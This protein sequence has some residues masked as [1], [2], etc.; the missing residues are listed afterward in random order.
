MICTNVGYSGHKGEG[1]TISRLCALFVVM[2]ILSA[3]Q[4]PRPA[5]VEVVESEDGYRL[6]VNGTPFMVNG[7]N[8][9]YFPIGTNYAFILWEQPDAFIEKALHDEMT[10]LQAM[11]VNAIRVYTGIQPRWV[12]YIYENYGIYTMLNHSFGRYGV[13]LESGWEPNT[14]YASPEVA[15]ILLEEV[16][17]LAR[18]FKDTPGLLL[19]LLGNE[20]N[21]GLFWGTAE[22]QD[23][24]TD[25]PMYTQRARDMYALFNR[26][27]LAIKEVDRGHPVAMANGDLQYLDLI[28]ELT[29]DIDIFGTNTYRGPTFTDLYDRVRAEFGKPVLLTEFGADAFN[30]ITQQEDQACQAQ[31]FKANWLDVYENAAGMGRAGNSIGGFTF[32]FS[33][34]WWKHGQDVELD[35]HNTTATWS[36]GGYRCDYVEGQNNMNEEW[37]GIMAKGPT[38]DTG[39]YTLTPRAAYHTIAQAHAFN[40]YA[41]GATLERLRQHF[42]QI[43]E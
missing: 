20:N 41:P 33:D 24:P 16:R 15:N 4:A 12:T 6:M 32:Q 10:L 1:R 29:P 43:Q 7:M 40:P 21:Y 22:T 18:D 42:N 25:D 36:N 5:P 13:M 23:F 14:D 11:G 2:G 26:G 19:Y 34:G 9:D 17:Q 31:I 27:A 28:V 35:V 3:C 38:S 8:W 30:A 37:F 39:H